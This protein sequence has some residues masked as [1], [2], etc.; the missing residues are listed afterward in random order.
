MV[1]RRKKNGLPALV[2]KK[3]RKFVNFVNFT[4]AP[5]FGGGGGEI[6]WWR[7]TPVFPPF[8]VVGVGNLHGREK[9]RPYVEDILAQ[10]FGDRWNKCSNIC[11][12][13][14]VNHRKVGTP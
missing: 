9:S 4:P 14:G 13:F 1:C 6:D 2:A 3:V 8:S 5:A 12:L 7:H 10:K 11:S